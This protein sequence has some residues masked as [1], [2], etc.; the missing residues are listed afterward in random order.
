MNILKFRKLGS[1]VSALCL[2]SE[3]NFIDNERVIYSLIQIIGNLPSWLQLEET[4]Q[5]QHL[6]ILHQREYQDQNHSDA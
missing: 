5:A 4:E 3:M 1:T 6:W 2:N